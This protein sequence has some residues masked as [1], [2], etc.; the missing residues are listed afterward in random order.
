MEQELEK[1]L[2]TKDK[3]ALYAG[4]FYPE[5]STILE[6]VVKP[7]LE[8]AEQ[9]S[10][11]KEVQRV[12]KIVEAMSGDNLFKLFENIYLPHFFAM[13]KTDQKLIIAA[14][15]QRMAVATV[16][17]KTYEDFLDLYFPLNKTSDVTVN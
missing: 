14:A 5:Y 16:A 12:A 9:F 11:E 3:Q 7:V 17:D 1:D 10:D 15:K 2:S 8:A 4:A 13:S 6:S